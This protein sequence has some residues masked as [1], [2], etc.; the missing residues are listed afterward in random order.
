MSLSQV[1][2][3]VFDYYEERGVTYTPSTTI[4]VTPNKNID[5]EYNEYLNIMEFN[6]RIQQNNKQLYNKNE[7][8]GSNSPINKDT[9]LKPS[10]YDLDQIS[11]KNVDEI[12]GGLKENKINTTEFVSKNEFLDNKSSY[13]N[14]NANDNSIIY[15]IIICILLLLLG[16]AYLKFSI[17]NKKSNE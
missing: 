11:N 7:N 3:D 14:S 4:I 5:F 9:I 17:F 15:I 6:N 8:F 2:Q 13:I 10:L 1:N 16:I 12:L